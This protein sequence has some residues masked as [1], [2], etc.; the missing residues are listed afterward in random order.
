MILMRSR[1]LYHD[2][3]ILIVNDS[4]RNYQGKLFFNYID[5]WLCYIFTWNNQFYF[6][7]CLLFKQ[8]LKNLA[9]LSFKSKEMMVAQM[10]K[11]SF[12]LLL[13]S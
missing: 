4:L 8:V 5:Y 13:K 11:M 7:T 3:A 9:L 2:N 12:S 1:I 6:F 10:V